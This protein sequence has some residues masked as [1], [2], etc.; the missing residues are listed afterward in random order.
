VDL[1]VDLLL[2]LAVKDIDLAVEVVALLL[3]MMVD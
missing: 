2:L 3:S 1:V